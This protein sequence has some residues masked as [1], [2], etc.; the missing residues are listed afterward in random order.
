[1]SKNVT[2]GDAGKKIS[3][4]VIYENETIIDLER[5]HTLIVLCEYK[6]D[7]FS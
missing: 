1:M 7:I 3:C 2:E 6:L 5:E 4:T